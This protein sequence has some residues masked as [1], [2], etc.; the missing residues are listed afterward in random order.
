MLF[1][2]FQISA[3][4]REAVA[5]V[6]YQDLFHIFSISDVI[7]MKNAFDA[8]VFANGRVAELVYATDLKLLAE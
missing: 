2:I 4:S 7:I 3:V 8:K 5:S 1:Q 6:N